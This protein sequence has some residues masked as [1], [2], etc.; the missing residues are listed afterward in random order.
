MKELGAALESHRVRAINQPV[1]LP[2]GVD[3]RLLAPFLVWIYVPTWWMGT[4]CTTLVVGLAVAQ[5]F[6]INPMMGLRRLRTLII[7][8]HKLPR[9]KTYS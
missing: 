7:G 6:G 2:F 4:L 1:V 5:H 9:P 3:A 8:G